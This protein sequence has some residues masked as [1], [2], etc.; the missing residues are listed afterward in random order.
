[1]NPDTASGPAT[2]V[3]FSTGDALESN[4]ATTETYERAD[5][6]KRRIRPE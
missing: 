6:D 5:D 1:M 3:Q 2:I 4:V